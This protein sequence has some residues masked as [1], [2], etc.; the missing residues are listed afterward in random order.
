MSF[1]YTIAVKM[2]G[3]AALV[4]GAGT[5]G[6]RK[7][8]GLLKAG[9]KVKLVSPRIAAPLARAV[10]AKGGS[11]RRGTYRA[12]D[13][14]GA[15]L[16]FAATDDPVLNARICAAA[17]KKGLLASCASDARQGAFGLP[18]KAEAGPIQITVS[19]GGSSPAL[20]KAISLHIQQALKGSGL[21]ALARRLGRSRARRQAKKMPEKNARK[22]EG[23][24][25]RLIFG[26]IK[27]PL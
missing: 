12:A 6:A 26:Y 1:D 8:R 7:V 21:P 27:T 16:V 3:R 14:S 13:L 23:K 10:A 9:A 5:V 17:A 11:L 18:A 2:K 20:A 4:V 19:T 25:P 15:S 22:N 24:T